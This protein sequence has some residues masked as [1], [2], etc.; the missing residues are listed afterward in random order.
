M[1][2]SKNTSGSEEHLPVGH[3]PRKQASVLQHSNPISA[4]ILTL[5]PVTRERNR[6]DKTYIWN[7]S[8]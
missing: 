5:A 3:P 6:K 8:T 1:L 4:G 2:L 7:K